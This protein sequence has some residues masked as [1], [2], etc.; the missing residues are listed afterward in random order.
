MPPKKIPKQMK[1]S[2]MKALKSTSDPLTATNISERLENDPDFPKSMRSPP[3]SFTFTMKALARELN[4][5]QTEVLAS[6]G[7]SRHGTPRLRVGY[8]LPA[9]MTLAEAVEKATGVVEKPADGT[10]MITI[11]LPSSHIKAMD[12]PEETIATLVANHLSDSSPDPQEP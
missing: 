8:S 11:R 4:F 3:R 9:E 10:Q 5:V 6:N 12:N 7:I 1:I 2:I